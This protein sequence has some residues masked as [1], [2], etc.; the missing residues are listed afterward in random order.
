[1]K[2]LAVITALY[3]SVSF[4]NHLLGF[5]KKKCYSPAKA[6]SYWEKLCPLSCV[7]PEAVGRKPRVVSKTAGT[8]FPNTDLSSGE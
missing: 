5:R 4:R 1:M 6:G 3:H 2:N 8:V 7:P